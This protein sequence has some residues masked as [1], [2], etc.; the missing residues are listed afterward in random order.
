MLILATYWTHHG[1][2]HLV[3][4]SFHVNSTW[5]GRDQI[6]DLDEIRLK[7]S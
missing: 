6:L 2:L 7:G 5:S 1:V 3:I 4:E